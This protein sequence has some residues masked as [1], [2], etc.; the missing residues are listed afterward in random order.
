MLDKLES[1]DFAGCL[2]QVFAVD[3]EGLDPIPLEL[4]HVG[5]LATAPTPAGR[6]PFA[7]LFLGPVSQ[8]Y[9]PQGTYRLQHPTLGSLELFIVPLG[10]QTGRMRYEAI[11]N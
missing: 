9:L 6:R 3:I 1:A 11:F 7:L 8:E 4:A 5:E 2:T 10:P